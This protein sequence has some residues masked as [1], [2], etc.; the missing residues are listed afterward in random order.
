MYTLGLIL[1]NTLKTIGI[2]MA[3]TYINRYIDRWVTIGKG[4]DVNLGHN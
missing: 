3:I 1:V 2:I 4:I